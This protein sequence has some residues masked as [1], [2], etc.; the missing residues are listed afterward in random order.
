M[1]EPTTLTAA[2]VATSMLVTATVA[3]VAP[4]LQFGGVQLGLRP[5]V[6]LAGFAGAV[7]GVALLNTVPSSGDTPRELLVTS[8]RRVLVISLS[9]VMAGYL[10]PLVDLLPAI[11][12]TPSGKAALLAAAAVLGAGMQKI[13]GALVA[14]GARRVGVKR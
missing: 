8:A 13:L 6:L 10:A 4:E 5:D 9:T 12:Q 1:A 3:A 11:A 7:A 14:G 2:T